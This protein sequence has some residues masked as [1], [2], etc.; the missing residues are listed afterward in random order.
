MPMN[1]E[2]RE[3]FL[4]EPRI[5]VLA[6]SDAQGQP[7]QAPVWYLWEDGAA[8]LVTGRTSRK[9]RNVLQNP[10]VSLCIDA[11]TPP[12]RAVVL[13]GRA[14][15]ASMSVDGLLERCAHL[16]DDVDR[17]LLPVGNDLLHVDNPDNTTSADGSVALHIRP[18]RVVSWDDSAEV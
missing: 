14:E 2:T 13:T 10:R 8:H 18:E 5:A 6:T 4:A 11:R 12:Y 7:H 1:D 9:W 15:E 17:I 16:F 3:R